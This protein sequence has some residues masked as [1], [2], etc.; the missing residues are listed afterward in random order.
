MELI[1]DILVDPQVGAVQELSEIT[2]VGHRVV[3]GGEEFTGSVIVDDRVL[4]SIERFVDLAPLHNPHNLVGIK[5]AKQ[6][7]PHAA[8]VA[9]FDTAF[10]ASIPELAHIIYMRCH[11][12]S[13][14]STVFAGTV[15]TVPL[16]GMSP[17]G[18]RP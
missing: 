8:Q 11:T 5:A 6:R 17:G 14:R 3:H 7:L 10:H 12:N 15:F 4:A 9:C 16:I 18:Q 13:T 1:F 2:T